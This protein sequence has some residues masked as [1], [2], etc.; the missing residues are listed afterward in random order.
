MIIRLLAGV[1]VTALWSTAA[2]ADWQLNNDESSLTFVS[3]KASTVAEVLTFNSLQGRVTEGGMAEL[4]IDLDSVD[5]A[6]ELRD[7]R[8]VEL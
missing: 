3:T 1:F 2:L 5:T 4:T 8:M 7:Q 6:I